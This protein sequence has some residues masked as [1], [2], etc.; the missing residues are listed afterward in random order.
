MYK[1]LFF[2]V[3]FAA[4]AIPAAAQD[5]SG[6]LASDSVSSAETNITVTATGT[7][8]ELE[9]TGQQVTIIGEEEIRAVQGPDLTRVLERVPGLTFS[10]NGGLGG[11][12]GV[13]L[14]GSEAEQVLI[15]LDGVRVSDPAAPSGGFDFGNLLSGNLAK[16]EVIRGS[17]STIWGSDAMGGVIVA[18]TRADTGLVAS[19]EYGADD[20]VTANASAGI[21]DADTGF[22]GASANFART[23]GFSSAASGTEADGFE[24]WAIEG[25][26]RYYFSDAFEVFARIRQTEGTLE[27]D[28]LTFPAYTLADTDE[29]QDTRQ[30]FGSAGAVLDTGPLFLT[31]SYSF[32][33]TAR[34]NLDGSGS[35][36]FSSDGESDRISLRGE[37]RPIGPLLLNFGAQNEWTSYETLYDTGDS[38][39]ILGAY[40]Q[41]GVEWRGISGHIGVRIDDHEDF[42]SEIS[43]GADISYELVDSWR[44]RASIGEGFKAPSL[45]QLLSDYGNRELSPE[46]STSYDFGIAYGDRALTDRPLYGAVTLYR[47][48]TEDQIAFVSCFG[49]STDI[50]TDRPYGTYDNQDRT[51]AQGVEAELRA[52]IAET[53]VLG[54]VYSLIETENRGAGPN[55]G[56]VLARRPRHAATFTGEWSPVP[57]LSLGA[58][59][60]VV[61][62]SFDDAGNSS[63]LEGYEV[64]S[65]RAAFDVT[66][67]VQIFG[68]VENVWDEDYQTAAGYAT[69]GSAAFVGARLAL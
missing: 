7:R 2:S 47:R 54:A 27:L 46:H 22:I 33:D 24:Q 43:F 37:W 48:D 5:G 59:L 39:S 67:A 12:T 53:V 11:F 55:A 26:G 60:R 18:S 3:S 1:Y 69:R 50:C 34:D 4:L 44:L 31:A 40:A 45:F 64:M 6:T 38:T 23:D 61:S 68:R 41:A 28:G 58:D 35:T 20:S 15:V 8:I 42:G 16:L 10:R 30:T 21:G 65:L 66:E 13:R 56:N 36:T 25:H 52:R 49:A 32:A 63:R 14:R 62:G 51:R 17:N 57:A 29:E 9:D 19:A